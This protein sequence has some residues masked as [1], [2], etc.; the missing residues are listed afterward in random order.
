MSEQ[1]ENY[2]CNICGKEVRDKPTLVD[3]LSNEHEPLEVAA[4][5]AT[6][7]IQEQDRD[8]D[9]QE[10]YRRMEQLKRELTK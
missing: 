1:S 2:R 10:Y 7:M 9:A 8:R 4:F 6:T 3:H 5:A